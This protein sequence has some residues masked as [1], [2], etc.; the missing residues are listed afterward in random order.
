MAD[1]H[2]SSSEGELE[3]TLLEEEARITVPSPQASTQS[4]VLLGLGFGGLQLV[5]A[6]IFSN[7]TGFL[8]SLHFSKPVA[9][10]V[11]MI[12]PLFGATLQP[13]FGICSDQHR[14]RYGKRRPFILPGAGATIIGLL[15]LA[16]SEDI[17]PAIASRLAFTSE[18]AMQQAIMITAVLSILALQ[19]AIQPLQCGLRSLVVDICPK[20]QQETANAWVGRFI[21]TANILS[22]SVGYVDLPRWVPWLGNSQFRILSVLTSITLATTVLLMCLAVQEDISNIDKASSRDHET[23]LQKLRYLCTCFPRLPKQVRRVYLIQFFA[24]MGWFP[25]LYYISLYI[26]II[27]RQDISTS[28]AR[29]IQPIS[30]DEDAG[31]IGSFG[32]L[33]FAVTSLSAGTG[34]PMLLSPP[35]QS[36][37]SHGM[38][39]GYGLKNLRLLWMASHILF[40]ICMWLTLFI[41]SLWGT[42]VLV[43]LSGISW[44]VTIWVPFAIIGTAIAENGSKS[45]AE[46]RKGERRPGVVLSLHNVAIATPQIA[47]A[48][49]SSLVFWALDADEGRWSSNS[50][51][52][53]LRLAALSTIAAAVMTRN[54]I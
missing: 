26:G 9:A 54:L 44:A 18:G 31:R 20:R 25:F 52:W 22:Y 10:L 7:G 38:R 49:A 16:W 11:W 14:S 5:F 30:L 35:G 4:L 27:Y 13:Y 19:A 51:G 39:Q 24:W 48:A 46:L 23:I 3:L 29:N 53:T 37:K 47:A 33:L 50:I 21:S 34:L 15:G 40:A 36:A 8:K 12:G 43:G 28:H 32:L 17:G 6:T 45:R 1:E 41:S 2:E 42:Y